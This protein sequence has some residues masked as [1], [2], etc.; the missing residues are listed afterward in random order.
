MGNEKPLFSVLSTHTL[1]VNC[2]VHGFLK[3]EAI[4]MLIS[5]AH[6]KASERAKEAGA[7]VGSFLKLIPNAYTFVINSGFFYI[8]LLFLIFSK[9]MID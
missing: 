3:L 7:A 6:S 5:M 2:C 1:N 4:N 9:Y 8:S